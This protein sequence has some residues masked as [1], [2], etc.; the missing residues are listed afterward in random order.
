M[1]QDGYTYE[2]VAKRRIYPLFQSMFGDK[3]VMTK[4]PIK[5]LLKGSAMYGMAADTSVFEAFLRSNGS[6]T[7][8]LEEFRAKYDAYLVQVRSAPMYRDRQ[9]RSMGMLAVVVP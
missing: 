7:S 9:G 3:P 1:L 2:S 5:Q 8:T 6:D 4:L